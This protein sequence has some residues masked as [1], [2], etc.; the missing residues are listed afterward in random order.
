MEMCLVNIG[1]YWYIE[2]DRHYNFYI[3]LVW[4]VSKLQ[5]HMHAHATINIITCK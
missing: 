2:T 3:T 5:L 4:A 1:K